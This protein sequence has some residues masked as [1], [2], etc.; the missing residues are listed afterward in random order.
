MADPSDD[1]P[2][3]LVHSGMTG[4][5]Y[6]AARGAEDEGQERL[7][8]TLDRGEF[9]Y[10]DLRKFA[11]YGWHRTTTRSPSVMGRPGP[12]TPWR[13]EPARSFTEAALR[14]APRRGSSP[15]LMDQSVIAGLGNMLTDEICWRARVQSLEANRRPQRR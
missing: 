11:E 3:L 14:G 10:A 4:H 5:P 7:V 12:P 9:R 13:L 6:F 1:G 8:I 15:T 2:T